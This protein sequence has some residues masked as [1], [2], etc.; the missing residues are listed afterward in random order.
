MS[1]DFLDQGEVVTP[2]QIS[3]FDHERKLL[4]ENITLYS[5]P[6]K[7]LYLLAVGAL[8]LMKYI[9]LRCITHPIFIY[10]F[11]PC[12]SVWYVLD[13]IQGPHSIILN[14]IEFGIEFVVWWLG[15]GI[16]SSIGLGS[17]LQSGVLF[18]FPHIF[19]VVFAANTCKTLDFDSNSNM[20][21][22]SPSSLFKCPTIELSSTYTPS[23]VTFFGLWKKVI[24][25]CF[26]QAAGT[27]IGEIPPYW[28][29][30]ATRLASIEA[31]TSSCEGIP[32]ELESNSKYGFVNRFKSWMISFLRS[33]GFYGV[34]AMAS[35][36]NIAFDVCGIC[37][38]HFLMPFWTFFW[39][40]FIGKAVIRNSY[41]SVIYLALCSERYLE[42][43]IQALQY[44]VP[45]G[46]HLDN[47][48]R[49][50]LEEGRTSFQSNLIEEPIPSVT[51]LN[52]TQSMECDLGAPT[53]IVLNTV[54]E[55]CTY[56]GI[57]FQF[58]SVGQVFMFWWK[59]FMATILLTFMMSCVN[60]FAQYFQLTVDQ[61]DSQKL[62][63]KL[64]DSVRNTLTS[65]QSGRLVLPP[66]SAKKKRPSSS[67]GS[68]S[69]SRSRGHGHVDEVLHQYSLVEGVNTPV[70]VRNRKHKVD[71]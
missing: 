41:Q 55:I 57:S 45:D 40:T 20:W 21:F 62:R 2:Q 42:L 24:L 23:P 69:K 58:N 30:R 65:P 51:L 66:P 14:N 34:L 5:Q 50:A 16:F 22:R 32:E 35:Y 46:L 26:L 67:S 49:E 25:I 17:G 8:T 43:L 10:L 60:Q 18:M 31:G 38:G 59:V 44:I 39:A 1:F 3:D 61:A 9:A 71:T 54:M 36:P 29:S 48:I 63:S 6:F 19:K 68:G 53:T 37:C 33:H 13:H 11:I 56:F 4:R 64:S 52:S 70:S 15:L 28:L 12:L 7:T 27:A 47:M